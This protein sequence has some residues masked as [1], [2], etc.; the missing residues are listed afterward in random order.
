MQAK[1]TDRRSG[2]DG[3]GCT[4]E[5]ARNSDGALLSGR[6]EVD[7]TFGSKNTDSGGLNRL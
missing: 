3:G 1:I 6:K 7:Q 4:G 5:F 2:E